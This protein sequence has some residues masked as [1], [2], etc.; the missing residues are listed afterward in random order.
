MKNKILITGADGFIGSHLTEYLVNKGCSV[1]AFTLY[2]SFNSWGCLDF[3]DEKIIHVDWFLGRRCN[4]D[5]VYCPPTI[6]DSTSSY[7]DFK[8]LQKDYK[9][10]TDIII[11]RESNIKNKIIN[12]ILAGGEPTLIPCY[13][14]FLEMINNDDRFN[15]K[16][17]TLTN[18]TGSLPKLYKLPGR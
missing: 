18:L 9:F 8:K 2:N 7:P 14:D 17:L 5:C 15:S 16:I 1:K 11:K 13:L 4:F 6:H 12:Y 3:I 10:L